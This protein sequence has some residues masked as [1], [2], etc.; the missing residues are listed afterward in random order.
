MSSCLDSVLDPLRFWEQVSPAGRM[1]IRGR[2]IIKQWNACHIQCTI[3]SCLQWQDSI[4]EENGIIE[5]T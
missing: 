3:S 4:G 2:H 1:D 5:Q